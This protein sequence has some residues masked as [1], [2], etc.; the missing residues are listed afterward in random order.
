MRD[1]TKPSLRV[2]KLNS[3]RA[4][5]ENW[6][7][8]HWYAEDRPPWFLRALEPVYR[9]GFHRA[10]KKVE[11]DTVNPAA[12]SGSR[13][14]VIIVGNI[15][16]GGSGKTPLVIRLCQLALEM[17]LKPGIAST[18]YGRQ[19][20]D[21]LVVEPGSDVR[22]CGDEPV[23]LAARTGVPVVVAADRA[24]A[25]K[26]LQAMDLD[27]II[28]DDGLQRAALPRDMEFCVIDGERGLGNGHLLPAGPLREP[29]ERLETVDHVVS[30]GTWR[31]KPPTIQVIEMALLASVVKSL[32]DNTEYPVGQFQRKYAGNIVHAVAGIGNPERFFRMLEGLG[33]K[34]RRHRFADHHAF[35]SRDFDSIRGEPAIIMTEKDAVKCRAL[36]LKN[37]WYMPVEARLPA[38]FESVIN[39]R[40][41]KLTKD[42]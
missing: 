42:S 40:F 27:L 14:A 34:V 41:S 39:D 10:Q 37:A 16:A 30:N 33:F 13:A 18:G 38:E 11:T 21:T 36:G 7:L 9:A 23:M 35:R 28:S 19:S 24:E 8:R 3:M 22:I 32:D 12:Q 20:K 15:T 1:C 17:Q 31:D 26:R 6:L 5:I 29:A 4:R 25:V 2:S